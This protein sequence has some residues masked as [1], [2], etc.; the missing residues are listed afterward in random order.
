[1]K[2]GPVGGTSWGRVRKQRG[3]VRSAT[4][5]GS[6]LLGGRAGPKSEGA[7]LG[8]LKSEA[9]VAKAEGQIRIPQVYRE[10]QL[11]R[12]TVPGQRRCQA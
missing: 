4:L 10:F 5:C 6:G 3:A 9:V 7:A 12:R 2:G 8:R 11:Q 1:M